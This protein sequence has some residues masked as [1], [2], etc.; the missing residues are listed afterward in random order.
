MHINRG[1]GEKGVRRD[2]R[3]GVINGALFGLAE[4][5][6]DPGLVLVAFVVALGGSPLLVGLAAAIRNAGWYLPHLLVSGRTQSAPRTLPIYAR[7]AVLRLAG[8][9]GV[10]VAPRL[11]G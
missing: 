11:L 10:A 1:G 6:T 4:T 7:A 3:L 5:L 8:W 2:F 9:G